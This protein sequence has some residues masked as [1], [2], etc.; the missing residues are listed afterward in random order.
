MAYKLKKIVRENL[1]VEEKLCWNYLRELNKV[2]VMINWHCKCTCHCVKT[3]MKF[4]NKNGI[5]DKVL[6]YSMVTNM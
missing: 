3:S 4:N 5:Q 6:K 2:H 1:L